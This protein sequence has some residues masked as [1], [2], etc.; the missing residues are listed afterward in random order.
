MNYLPGRDLDKTI[1][2]R[3]LN[4]DNMNSQRDPYPD[5][6]FDYMS[7]ITIS[8]SNGRVIFPLLE[9]FGADLAQILTDSLSAA[10]A[11]GGHR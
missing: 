5:G 6:I 11:A 3:L 7:G 4:L 2:I 9:P 8:P 10:D 1:L